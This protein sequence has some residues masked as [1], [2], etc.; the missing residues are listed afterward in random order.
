MVG[1]LLR[2]CSAY[3][4]LCPSCI[5]LRVW[6]ADADDL[7]PWLLCHNDEGRRRCRCSP[8]PEISSHHDLACVVC[9]SKSLCSR[10]NMLLPDVARRTMR[11]VHLCSRH[12]PPEHLLGM[13]T[14][15]EEFDAAVKQYNANK[16]MVRK[17]KRR[18]VCA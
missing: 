4:Y 14:C 16:S 13:V 7:C 12:A 18:M 11:R 2:V 6:A 8:P 10:A 1:V 17:A 9:S 3:F 5:S 15:V